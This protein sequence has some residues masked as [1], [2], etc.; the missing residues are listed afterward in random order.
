M[1]SGPSIVLASHDGI[2]FFDFQWKS[3][4]NQVATVKHETQQGR[5]RRRASSCA[6][7]SNPAPN[8]RA[9]DPCFFLFLASSLL[10]CFHRGFHPTI[11]G[12]SRRNGILLPGLHFEVR[13]PF[14]F[15]S[16]F[17]L[18]Q[19]GFLVSTL[20]GYNCPKSRLFSS[21]SISG[22]VSE[23][24]ASGQLKPSR[25]RLNSFRHTRSILNSIRNA[26]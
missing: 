23:R 24:D 16:K 10:D 6:L 20:L 1:L 18:N 19:N 8:S 22:N 5:I 26:V 12:T 9:Q 2:Y 11:F 4:T 7:D 14:G 25:L 15:S 21:V 3:P 17:E 13:K